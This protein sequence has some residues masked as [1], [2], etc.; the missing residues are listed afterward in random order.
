MPLNAGEIDKKGVSTSVRRT[1]APSYIFPSGARESTLKDVMGDDG[2]N[3]EGT[4][5]GC[6]WGIGVSVSFCW[7]QPSPVSNK[8]IQQA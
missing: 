2:C 4:D 7:S 8:L 1:L 3:W 6:D 5:R